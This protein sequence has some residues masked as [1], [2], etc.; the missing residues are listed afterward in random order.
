MVLFKEQ[1][2]YLL[3]NRR[4]SYEKRP[5]FYLDYRGLSGSEMGFYLVFVAFLKSHCYKFVI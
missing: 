4:E 1:E 2:D 5:N 3:H